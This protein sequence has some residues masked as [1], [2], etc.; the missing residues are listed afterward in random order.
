MNSYAVRLLNDVHES[1]FFRLQ[2]KDK[3]RSLRDAED[4][5]VCM[6]NVSDQ[7]LLRFLDAHLYFDTFTSSEL[8]VQLALKLTYLVTNYPSLATVEVFVSIVKK[9]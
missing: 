5:K 1:F 2:K 9:S 8:A 4:S 6:V 7:R 3:I